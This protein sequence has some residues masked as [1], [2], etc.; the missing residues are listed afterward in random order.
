MYWSDL[1]VDLLSL[2]VDRELLDEVLLRLYVDFDLPFW[3]LRGGVRFGD[4]DLLSL[5]GVPEGDLLLGGGG[6]PSGVRPRFPFGVA[7]ADGLLVKDF[8]FLSIGT[9]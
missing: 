2:D 9:S 6:V 7:P 8:L 3:S 5:F 4:R 1:W